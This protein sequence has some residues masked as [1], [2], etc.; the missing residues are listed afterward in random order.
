MSESS[1]AAGRANEWRLLAWER[2]LRRADLEDL[3]IGSPA[4]ETP[5]EA[6]TASAPKRLTAEFW[7]GS[8]PTTGGG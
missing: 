1:E 2:P 8:R 4:T 6:W 5:I 7:K 3:A